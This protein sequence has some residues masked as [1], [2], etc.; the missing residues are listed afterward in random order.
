MPKDSIQNL[1]AT[2]REGDGSA[3]KELFDGYLDPVWRATAGFGLSNAD[4]E[5]VV[6]ETFIRFYRHIHEYDSRKASLKTYLSVIAKR[7]CIDIVRSLQSIVSID[8]VPEPPIP[9]A[10]GPDAET[11]AFLH[12]AIDTDLTADQRLCL[13]LFYFHG[14]SYDDIADSL[15]HDYHWVKNTLHQARI[16]LRQELEKRLE[17]RRRSD[18]RFV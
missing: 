2:A 9:A 6:Q 3:W 8:S 4:R 1:I 11:I 15:G 7:N 13:Q 17:S 10:E 12:D 5:D 14:L 18:A 16:Q